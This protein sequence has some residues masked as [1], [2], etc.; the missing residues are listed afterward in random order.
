[1]NNLI[2]VGS[3]AGIALLA[4]L[5][6]GIALTTIGLWWGVLLV[7]RLFLGRLTPPWLA[8]MPP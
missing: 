4:L 5:T 7:L 1:M 2:E 6:I 3:I 8:A